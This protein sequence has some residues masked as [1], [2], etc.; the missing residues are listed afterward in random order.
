M[1]LKAGSKEVYML[2][3]NPSNTKANIWKVLACVHN[4]S[5][6]VCMRALFSS[7][8]CGWQPWIEIPHSLYCSRK[9]AILLCRLLLQKIELNRIFIDLGCVAVLLFNLLKLLVWNWS[10]GS[11]GVGWQKNWHY[12]R[13]IKCNTMPYKNDV[14]LNYKKTFFFNISKN[15]LGFNFVTF[16]CCPLKLHQVFLSYSCSC[17]ANLM[18]CKS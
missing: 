12:S 5:L 1:R 18:K 10:K 9:C 14:P 2:C 8:F 11:K 17:K 3:I 6:W 4:I 15:S 16:L 7:F 13:A